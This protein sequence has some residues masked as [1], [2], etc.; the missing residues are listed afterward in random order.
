[1]GVDVPRVKF[2]LYDRSPFAVIDYVPKL[3][4]GECVTITCDFFV[5]QFITYE[6]SKS[7]KKEHHK[8]IPS[9]NIL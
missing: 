9:H 8:I 7:Y 1:M 4:R 5:L 3:G 2:I 6:H